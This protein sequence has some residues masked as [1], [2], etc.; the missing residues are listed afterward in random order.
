[1]NQNEI[2]ALVAQGYTHVP[3]HRQLLADFET[4]LSVYM[5][6]GNQP[7]SYLFESAAQG[8]ERWSRYSVIG[9]PSEKIFRVTGNSLRIE[10]KGNVI[11]EVTTDDPLE[12]INTYL[13]RMKVAEEDDMGRFY[14]G[15]A[16]YFGYDTIRFYEHK[17]KGSCPP[18]TL[19]TS[20]ILLMES[21][22]VVVFDNVSS[23][24]RLIT[25]GDLN[26]PEM[27]DKSQRKLDQLTD[28]LQNSTWTPP[29]QIDSPRVSEASFIAEYGQD[30]FL[31]DVE[32][33]RE[34]IHAGD[35]MQVV[36]AQRFSTEFK[37]PPIQLYR[38]LR[39]LNPSPYMYFM[40]LD[41]FHIVGS[42][43]EILARVEDGVVIN[44]PLA[45]TRRRGHTP[46]EDLA[47]EEEL[48]NDPKEI[49]EHLMLID[50][51]RN[52]VGRVCKIGSVQVTDMFVVERY[53]HVMHLASNVEGQLQEGKSAIDVLQATLPVGTLSGSP[54]IRAMEIIDEL[55][56][57]KRGVYA[58]AV[59][60]LGWNGNMDTAITIRT[61]V[62]KDERLY[63]HTGAGIVA[64]SVP[65]LEWKECLNKAR[66]MFKATEM[67]SHGSLLYS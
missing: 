55:E 63:I 41:D 58:G 22:D 23:T 61:A 45:G 37:I 48:V 12:Q 46:E 50:L 31:R 43:P 64:D 60:Y 25:L 4:P 47:L 6:L 9:L 35:V 5:K 65:E 17:L 28:Q 20:D 13:E 16:G 19:N 30:Q 2:D 42:S 49:A 10:E 18:D 32:V 53:A 21:K 39:A 14:G 38:A 44:R 54:K 57:V 40:Y 52:D 8:G 29:T 66:S 56:P 26:D 24:V 67:A 51:G 7:F 62:I 27:W 1:M 11:H 36:L 59:G 15:L 33:I 34:Y 3:I